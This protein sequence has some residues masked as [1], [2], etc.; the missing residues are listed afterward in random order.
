MNDERPTKQAE[1]APAPTAAAAPAAKVS[2]IAVR[3]A[4]LRAHVLRFRVPARVSGEVRM[5]QNLWRFENKTAP[6]GDDP[7]L[8][9]IEHAVD[10]ALEHYAA[11][12]ESRLLLLF[13]VRAPDLDDVP[14]FTQDV[15]EQLAE[16]CRWNTELTWDDSGPALPIAHD[17]PEKE[18]LRAALDAYL[19]AHLDLS[20]AAWMLT[21]RRCWVLRDGQLEDDD[22]GN[23]NAG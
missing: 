22:G 7:K 6:D 23:G 10:V 14:D 19:R 21:G 18:A 1:R 3:V 16:D 15:L 9:S 5:T 20:E 8:R 2:R 4:T 17:S 12:P 13:E 11:D